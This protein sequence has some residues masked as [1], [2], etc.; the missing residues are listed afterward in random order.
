MVVTER[1]VGDLQRLQELMDPERD[2]LRH[3]RYRA[4]RLAL[5]GKE[6]PDIADRLDRSRRSVQDW[7]YAYRDGGIDAIQPKPRPGRKPKLPREREAEKPT[8]WSF[9]AFAIFSRPCA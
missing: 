9:T 1:D 6:A 4:V 5:Q 3:D 2:S 7:V 8:A